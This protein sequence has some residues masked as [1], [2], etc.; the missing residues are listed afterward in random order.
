MMMI[1]EKDTKFTPDGSSD[2]SRVEKTNG[3]SYIKRWS[4]RKKR[5]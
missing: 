2:E 1:H 5:R 3:S 4:T